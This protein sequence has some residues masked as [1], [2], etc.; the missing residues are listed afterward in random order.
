MD[1]GC[2]ARTILHVM[3]CAE[4]GECAGAQLLAVI[5]TLLGE[6]LVEAWSAGSSGSSL[7]NGAKWIV[8]AC[9]PLIYRPDGA[10]A[11][12]GS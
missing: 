4:S 6:Q 7:A 2:G 12:T 10:N 9:H 8:V 3:G 11:G 1:A 5:V